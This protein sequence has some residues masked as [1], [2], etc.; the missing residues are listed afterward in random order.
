M[1]SNQLLTLK[2]R[3]KYGIANHYYPTK[4]FDCIEFSCKI[5]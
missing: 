4:G 2:Y 1:V 3:K 5:C